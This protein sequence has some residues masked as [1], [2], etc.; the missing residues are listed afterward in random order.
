MSRKGEIRKIIA[1][2][3]AGVAGAFLLAAFFVVN[4]SPSSRYK[5]G[6]VLLAP[7]VLPKLNYNDFNP[8][9]STNDRY[10]F[11]AVKFEIFPLKIEKKATITAYRSFYSLIKSDLSL[12]KEEGETFF[13]GIG[14]DLLVLVKTE[15][16]SAWQ[17]DNKTFQAIQ[18]AQGGN[19]YRIQLHEDAKGNAWA[20]FYHP[21]IL[22]A[23]QSTFLA[24]NDGK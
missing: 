24:P 2:I 15:S 22:N 14:G 7:D 21:G 9:I 1:V 3:F 5:A 8:K 11:D 17:N 20:Y 10:I 16:S 6:D 18:F 12:L 13:S 23:V 4:F 19:H